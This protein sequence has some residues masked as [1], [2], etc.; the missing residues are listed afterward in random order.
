MQE[1]NLFNLTDRA[2]ITLATASFFFLT[3][4]LVFALLK[5]R[6]ALEDSFAM[7]CLDI[8]CDKSDIW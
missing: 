7:T 3:W 8:N 4:N 6:V 2:Q 1:T 5:I